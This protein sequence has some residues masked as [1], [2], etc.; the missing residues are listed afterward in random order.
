MVFIHNKE[1]V[2]SLQNYTGQW[3]CTGLFELAIAA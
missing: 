2:A 1:E 3:H